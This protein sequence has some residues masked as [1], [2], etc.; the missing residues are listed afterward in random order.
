MQR[1]NYSAY[2]LP[3]EGATVIVDRQLLRLATYLTTPI[4]SATPRMM[5]SFGLSGRFRWLVACSASF[6]YPTAHNRE[7][8]KSH[9]KAVV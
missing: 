7:L 6:P 2:G 5:C 4:V 8:C 1:L 9:P 3:Y